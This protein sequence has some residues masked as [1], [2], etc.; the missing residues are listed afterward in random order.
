MNKKRE[1]LV[2]YVS[3]GSNISRERFRYYIDGGRM[4]A[5]GHVHPGC[6]DTT[7]PR[8]IKRLVIPHQLYYGTTTSGWGGGVAFIDEQVS[9]NEHTK[10]YAY[11]ITEEQFADVVAQENLLTRR[12]SLSTDRIVKKKRYIMNELGAYGEML[13]LGDIDGIPSVTFTA[14]HRHHIARP[15]TS[16]LRQI[17]EGLREAY[18]MSPQEIAQYFRRQPGVHGRLTTEELLRLQK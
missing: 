14:P 15:S 3:Y 6:R 5:N 11:L 9:K 17:S 7:P 2:W 12:I 10:G 8:R 16:Y 4:P 18:R 13:Y 1:K